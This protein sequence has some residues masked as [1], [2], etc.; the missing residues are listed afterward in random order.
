MVPIGFVSDHMEVMFDL[1]EEASQIC[2]ELGIPM[3]RSL[4]AGTHPSFV[5]MIR[6]LIEERLQENPERLAIGQFGPNHDVCQE[7]CCPE[8]RPMTIGRPPMA[9]TSVA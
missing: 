9:N 7:Y 8:M 5:K 6:L 4:S 2:D 1:D 3:V